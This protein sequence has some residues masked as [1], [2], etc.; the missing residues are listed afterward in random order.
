[1]ITYIMQ[2]T[3]KDYDE[4]YALL[5]DAQFVQD[6][7]LLDAYSDADKKEKGEQQ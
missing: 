5:F 2:I 4:L 3:V 7:E 1:M 6:F